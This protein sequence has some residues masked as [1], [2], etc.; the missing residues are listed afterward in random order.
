MRRHGSLT[1]GHVLFAL[2]GR[3]LIKHIEPTASFLLHSCRSEVAPC[4]QRVETKYLVEAAGAPQ[5]PG[6]VEFYRRFTVFCQPF[7]LND[8]I[9]KHCLGEEGKKS[10][11]FSKFPVTQAVKKWQTYEYC[12]QI[13]TT[14]RLKTCWVL[15]DLNKIAEQL[16]RRQA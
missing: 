15:N 8:S 14:F 16:E 3:V 13:W 11:A 6:D 5:A 10:Y 7:Q 12:K 4:L 1:V 2:N 9:V